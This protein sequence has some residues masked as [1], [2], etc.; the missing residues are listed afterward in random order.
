MTLF[1]RLSDCFTFAPLLQKG[2]AFIFNFKYFNHEL[3]YSFE[4]GV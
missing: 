2:M 1:S 3:E 4:L